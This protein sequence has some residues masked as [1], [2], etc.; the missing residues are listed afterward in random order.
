MCAGQQELAGLGPVAVAE[1]GENLQ[2]T[3]YQEKLAMSLM[4]GEMGEG[5]TTAI[6]GLLSKVDGHTI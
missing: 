2:C 6:P 1:S 3:L 4:R 5:G